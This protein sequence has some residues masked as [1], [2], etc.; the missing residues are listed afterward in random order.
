MFTERIGRLGMAIQDHVN[1]FIEGDHYLST[2][3]PKGASWKGRQSWAKSSKLTREIMSSQPVD[4]LDLYT[5][6]ETITA[7]IMRH[8]LARRIINNLQNGRYSLK[9]RNN[10]LAIF[11]QHTDSLVN[12][13]VANLFGD[14][15]ENVQEAL[16][17][18]AEGLVRARFDNYSALSLN[19]PRKFAA[20]LKS[21]M[22]EHKQKTGIFRILR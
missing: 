3:A 4:F 15:Q 1:S 5:E 6:L 9:D 16:N 18:L 10:D 19:G 14:D 13:K 8:Q 17:Y 12:P 7:Y 21:S 2:E 20:D 22:L 11:K